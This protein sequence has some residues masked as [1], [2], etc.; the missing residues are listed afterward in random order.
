[1]SNILLFCN[2]YS[3]FSSFSD[4]TGLGIEFYNI[5]ILKKLIRESTR[6]ESL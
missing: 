5:V 1:M 2:V 4:C 3:L 6:I